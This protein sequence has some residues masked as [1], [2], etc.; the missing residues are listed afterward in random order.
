METKASFSDEIFLQHVSN[1]RPL[2]DKSDKGYKSVLQKENCW[3]S[4][5]RSLS[6]TGMLPHNPHS[7]IFNIIISFICLVSEAKARFK[8][9]R[10][11][12][13]RELQAIE[14]LERSGAPASARPVWPLMSFFQYMYKCGEESQRQTTSNFPLEEDTSHSSQ[15]QPTIS[16]EEITFE[17]EDEY[18]FL[19]N[20]PST[21]STN[22]PLTPATPISIS[23]PTPKKIKTK[24]ALQPKNITGEL[25]Q[26]DNVLMDV[27][28]AI[29]NLNTKKIE[30]NL[31][32]YEL[33]SKFLA[34][35]L[36]NIS[37]PHASILM[38]ELQVVIINYKRELRA[39][40]DQNTIE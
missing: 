27:S 30:N 20:F 4:I 28:T 8:S 15:T 40:E 33:F 13:R 23:E 29:N 14:K 7:L 26:I 9:L 17:I 5:A 10:E 37:E 16:E 6:C 18:N 25:K 11:K 19:D 22:N 2:Y 31:D 24:A 34:S 3:A 32:R 36:R 38:E 12:Y 35:E 21:S 39:S 1:Y